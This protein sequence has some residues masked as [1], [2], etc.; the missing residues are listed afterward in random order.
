M[1]CRLTQKNRNILQVHDDTAEGSRGRG[2]GV[3]SGLRAT[4]K[5]SV[6][7]GNCKAKRQK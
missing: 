3:W 2:G 4:E 5:I 6:S 1:K 7:T